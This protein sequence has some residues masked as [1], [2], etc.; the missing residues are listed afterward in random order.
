MI[1]FIIMI[2]NS[3]AHGESSELRTMRQGYEQSVLY[4]SFDESLQVPLFPCV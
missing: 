2:R 3:G 1:L 4:C